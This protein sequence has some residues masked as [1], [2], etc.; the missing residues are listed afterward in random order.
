MGSIMLAL[1]AA[2]V[3]PNLR[4]N[5]ALDWALH[6]RWVGISIHERGELAAALAGSCGSTALPAELLA[7][8]DERK[9]HRALAWGLATR[10][11]RRLNAGSH[12]LRANCRLVRSDEA[13]T[14]EVHPG[15]AALVNDSARSDLAAL[16]SWNGLEDRVVIG[17]FSD[18]W[19]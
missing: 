13:L 5:H 15:I 3:E 18:P 19:E 10:L 2:R 17:E 12:D 16:A 7:L 8:T 9:L 14:L 1:A 4:L 11:C 6:K